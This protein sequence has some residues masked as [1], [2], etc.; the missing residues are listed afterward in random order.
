MLE[1][2]CGGTRSL[3]RHVNAIS[4]SHAGTFVICEQKPKTFQRRLCWNEAGYPRD[5]AVLTSSNPPRWST[6]TLRT[7][8]NDV[9]CKLLIW[10]VLGVWP[11]AWPTALPEPVSEATPTACER[12]R[13]FCG[14]TDVVC[15]MSPPMAEETLG[16][17]ASATHKLGKSRTTRFEVSSRVCPKLFRGL[18][19]KQGRHMCRICAALNLLHMSRARLFGP[20]FVPGRS[21]FIVLSIKI[22]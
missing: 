18:P 22:F 1:H 4:T 8:V 10:A 21:L 15:D 2:Q 19:V 20:P 12:L 7:C 9:T 16:A 5:F 3:W 11:T 17:F 13:R 6:S 14:G